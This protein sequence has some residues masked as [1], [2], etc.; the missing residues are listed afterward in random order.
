MLK[1]KRN[2]F[3]NIARSQIG[4]KET[5]TNNVKYN[6]WY[7]GRAVNGR[8]GTSEYAW[9]VTFICWCANQ[10]GILNSLIPR[11]NNVGYIRE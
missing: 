6:T 4:I 11:H 5:G 1:S 7:Y 3:I 2:D 9:C 8:T 10:I